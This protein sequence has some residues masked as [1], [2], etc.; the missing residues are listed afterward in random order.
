MSSGPVRTRTRQNRFALAL[1]AIISLFSSHHLSAGDTSTGQSCD[2]E[3][4]DIL[5]TNDDG[6]DKPG[7]RALHRV[8]SAAKH[9]LVLAAPA[10]NASGSSTSVTFAPVK[11]N[12]A[13]PGIYAIEASPAST[14]VLGVNNY[15]PDGPPDLVIS[16]IN[17]GANLGPATP[18]SGTVGA[19]IAALLLVQPAIPA[20]A[21]STDPF[22]LASG[23][24][25]EKQQADLEHLDRVA[26]FILQLVSR[27]QAQSCGSV[28]LLPQG[29]ALNINYPPVP[30]AAIK[31][32]KLTRQSRLPTFSLSYAP[33]AKDS[34]LF[35]PRFTELPPVLSGDE[36]DTSA[37]HR[38]YITI[39]PIDGNYTLDDPGARKLGALLEG[40]DDKP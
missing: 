39:V 40:L 33:S 23:S 18:V 28:A 2:G 6:Y 26:H 35:A 37:Y 12:E 11:V 25:T 4:L 19:T 31:G 1:T 10:G 9:R 8:F 34:A 20:I 17:K 16:G 15:F 29:L 13:E 32:F 27:L 24:E 38:G 30:Q 3:P 14:V 21:V 5:L 36:G 22:I 7:I